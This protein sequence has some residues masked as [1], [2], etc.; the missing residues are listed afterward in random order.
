MFSDVLSH[1]KSICYDVPSTYKIFQ[2]RLKWELNPL[3]ITSYVAK[4]VETE[5]VDR[6]T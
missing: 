4:M 2:Q 3:L 6:V 1:Y 5:Q